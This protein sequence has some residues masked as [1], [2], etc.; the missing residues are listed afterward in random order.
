M[1]ARWTT[2]SGA[3]CCARCLA[4]E[5]Y[6]TVYRDVITPRRVAE[7]LVLRDD[8]PRSLHRCLTQVYTHLDGVAQ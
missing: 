8:M 7:L 3:R 5:I 4:F 1:A 2:T 6:R